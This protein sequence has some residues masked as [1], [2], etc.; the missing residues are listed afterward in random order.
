MGRACL[1]FLDTCT[2]LW[3]TL[4]PENLSEKASGL[5]EGSS[6]SSGIVFSAISIWEIAVK[7]KKKKLDLGLGVEEY[8]SKLKKTRNVE[9]IPVDEKIW[10]SSVHLD[11]KHTDHVDRVIVSNAM[12]LNLPLVTAD[13][14][15]LDYYE[16]AVW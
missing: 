5:I 3:W 12:E 6:K 4:A 10:L 2:L 11:W 14:V 13:K 9:I 16:R 1:I 15:I 7:C 8:T